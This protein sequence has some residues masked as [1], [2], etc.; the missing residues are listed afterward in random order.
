MVLDHIA[1]RTGLVVKAS[2]PLNAKV[3]RHRDLDAL[4]V[5]PIPERLNKRVGEA[6][7]QHVVQ[8]AFSEIVVDTKDVGLIENAEQDFVEFLSR[9]Q[10]MSEGFLHDDARSAI[11]I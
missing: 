7:C 3:L 5:V 11:T 1:D 6:E 2:T 9:C 8:C 10:I 4:D